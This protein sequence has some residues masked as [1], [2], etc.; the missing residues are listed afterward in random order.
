MAKKNKQKQ[1]GA[2]DQ[3]SPGAA[4]QEAEAGPPRR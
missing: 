4:W 3:R 1:H 2:E